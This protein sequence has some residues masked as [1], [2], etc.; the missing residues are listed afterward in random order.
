MKTENTEERVIR[1]LSTL[2]TNIEEVRLCLKSVE[3]NQHFS[4]GTWTSRQHLFL[5]LRAGNESGYGECVISV[6]NPEVSL[7][8]RHNNI[9][10]LKGL[11]VTDAFYFLR[12]QRGIFP[13]TIVE[14][15]EME[16]IDIEGK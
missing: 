1:E 2:N 10:M 6:N 15:E 3:V 8:E 7:D 12:T 9:N 13:E 16:L 14:L 5:V 4:F 11:S